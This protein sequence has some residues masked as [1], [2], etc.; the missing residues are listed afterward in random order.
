MPQPA[1]PSVERQLAES[2]VVPGSAL[3]KLIRDNQD[4]HLLR[5]EEATDK[6][7]L[8][9]WLRV[10][11]RKQHPEVEYR[12]DDPTGGYPRVLKNLHAWMLTHQDLQPDPPSGPAPPTD[13]APTRVAEVEPA[14]PMA[15]APTRA[16]G[17]NLRISG[18]QTT[19]RS[20]S[21]IRVN[22]NNAS[23]IIAASNAINASR[24]A[25]FSSTDGGATWSPTTLPLVLGDSLHSD[26]TVDWTS[27]GTAWATTIGIQGATLQLRAY[28]S[29]FPFNTWTF[30][31]TLSGSQTNA[32]KQM[33]WVDHSP[34]SPFKDTIYVIWHNGQP[35]FIN[36]RTG[37]AGAWQTPIQVSGTETTGFGIGGDI[38]TNSFGD[39]FAF[40]PDTGSR[41]LLVA[42]STN[43]G[44]SFAAP[45]TIATTKDSYDIGMPSFAN[46]RALIYIS[47]GAYRTATKDLVY[48]IWVDLT[49][50]TGCTTS[51]NEP[52]A[53]ATSTCKTRT[54]FSRSTNGG[55]T[56]EAPRMIN[57]QAS[58]NDQF[59]PWL[60]VDETNGRLV[61][62][63]YD[64]VDG[65]GRLRSD[66]WYQTSSDNGVTWSTPV[67]VTTA[68]TDE[69]GSGAD[70]GNQYGDYNGLSGYAGKFFS[71]WTDRRSGSRE[72]I[73]TALITPEG[74]SAMGIGAGSTPVGQ[75]NWQDYI[76]NNVRLGIY[77]DVDTSAAKFS[78]TPIYV[79]AIGGDA[80]HWLTTGGSAI[81]SPT[82]TGFRIYVRWSSDKDGPNPPNPLE[83]Q[84]ARDN[85][86]YINWIGWE[87]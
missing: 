42:K 23:Q 49:G 13:V 57:N 8:P 82:A 56:W 36:R 3:E 5:S 62:I 87:P 30:D 73:W 20:E 24:L 52:G 78:G 29:T 43:G 79:S 44:A 27:D 71:S 46:R 64:T 33:M 85:H 11:W 32:D 37:P 58:L 9:Q 63:Y 16:I 18:A 67:K 75:T 4:F 77:V 25:Q 55:T 45:V 15:V 26:P 81:Y 7:G 12:A 65:P 19:P 17:T 84:F 72:E 69:T 31:A 28:R 21:D 51:A 66:V 74:G 10:Y 1:W 47:G 38:K 6:I 2:N 48:A 86:W 35:A 61:V 76:E 68:Q 14:A 59:N 22:Y 50:A 83:P 39:V 34:T 60:A 80:W 54:W 53:S 41:R 40:W 70:L